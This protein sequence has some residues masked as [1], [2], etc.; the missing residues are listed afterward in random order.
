[1]TRGDRRLH[2]CAIAFAAVCAAGAGHATLSTLAFFHLVSSAYSGYRHE[3]MV[4]LLTSAAAIALA[5]AVFSAIGE[6]LSAPSERRAGGALAPSALD[7]ARVSTVALVFCLQLPVLLAVETVEQV[8]QFGHP[9]G[10]MASLGGP[11]LI[12]LV[13]HASCAIVAASSIARGL[14]WIARACRHFARTVAP[15]LRAPVPGASRRA[16][17][18]VCSDH[19]AAAS[20]LALR[21]ANRPPP[22]LSIA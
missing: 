11:V 18:A 3:S 15:L 14:S 13:V 17:R 21:I 9:L 16:S 19:R 4:V 5:F 10:I 7:R 6:V 8:H 1:M 22:A 12:A 20:P 2:A